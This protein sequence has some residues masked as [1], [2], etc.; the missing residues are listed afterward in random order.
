MRR[1]AQAQQTRQSVMPLYKLLTAVA[2]FMVL[3]VQSACL[4]QQR[5]RFSKARSKSATLTSRIAPDIKEV[6]A[7]EVLGAMEAA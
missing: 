7:T 4:A 6:L 2:F 3:S 1:S 5:I